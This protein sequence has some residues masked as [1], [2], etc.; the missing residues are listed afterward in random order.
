MSK[1]KSFFAAIICLLFVSNL[2]AEACDPLKL[3]IVIT[4]NQAWQE[5]PAIVCIE[6]IWEFD[7][8]VKCSE[9]HTGDRGPND[10]IVGAI[11]V[12]ANLA[13][14]DPCPPSPPCLNKENVKSITVIVTD[15]ESGFEKEV[16]V[17]GY[18]GI[19]SINYW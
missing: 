7:N 5:I 13:V 10:A 19:I 8:G 1:F 11:L 15:C 12:P 14:G 17:Y 18:Q 3:D 6:V 16:K 4:Y 9:Y 2:Y